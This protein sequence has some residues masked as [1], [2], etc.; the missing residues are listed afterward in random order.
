MTLIIILNI[1]V[2]NSIALTCEESYY[3]KNGS[4][5]KCPLYCYE[6]SCLDEVG[7]TKCKE[8]NFLSDDGKCYAC[9]TGCLSCTDSTHCQ[10]CSDGFDKRGDKCCMARCD[11]HCKCNSCNENGC[12]SCVNG[13][14]VNNSQCLSCPLHCDLCTFSQCLVCENGYSYDSIT[15]S[16]IQNQTN[17]FT[18]RLIFTILCATVCLLFII[19]ITSIFLILK[20]EREERIKKVVKTL[21]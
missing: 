9:Q 8:G 1:F 15:K 12:M 5:L 20:R 21:L 10:Q 13:F 18:M 14:Y 19:A 16:C 11:V 7:C 2:F 3:E 6:G 4:C 17:N